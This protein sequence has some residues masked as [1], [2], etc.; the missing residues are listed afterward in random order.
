[1]LGMLVELGV[2][3]LVPLLVIGLVLYALVKGAER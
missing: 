1:M 3:A 2:A